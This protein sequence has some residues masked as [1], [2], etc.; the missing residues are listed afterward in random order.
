MT[1]D[2]PPESRPVDTPRRVHSGWP[3]RALLRTA[4]GAGIF[5]CAPR[6][7]AAQAGDP[8]TQRPL[9]GDRFVFAGGARI[10]QVIT[11]GDLRSEERRCRER[12]EVSVG[13]V[14]IE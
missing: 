13:A 12:G 14:M 7:A 5:L 11:L 8:R 2:S 4:L 1:C 3:R 10:G 9:A 6:P